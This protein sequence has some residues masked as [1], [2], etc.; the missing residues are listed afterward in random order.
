MSKDVGNLFI[1]G[2]LDILVCC[3]FVQVF[4]SIF[5][6]LLLGHRIIIN[7]C[8]FF[9]RYVYKPYFSYIY[10]QLTLTM[11]WRRNARISRFKL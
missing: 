4:W 11:T 6:S 9:V 1:I 2:H 7:L 3:V 5:F 10:Y 8:E